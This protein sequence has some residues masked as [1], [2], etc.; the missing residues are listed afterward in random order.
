MKNE[1]TLKRVSPCA[2][3]GYPRCSNNQRPQC[4]DGTRWKIR[5]IFVIAQPKFHWLLNAVDDPNLFLCDR[6][7]HGQCKDSSRPACTDGTSLTCPDGKTLSKLTCPDGKTLNLILIAV[8]V[9]RQSDQYVQEAPQLQDQS[10]QTAL[11]WSF[12]GLK[13]KTCL[14]S[15]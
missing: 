13:G 2:A 1:L 6:P 15:D 8:L 4:S 9:Q 12:S 3:G 14:P 7:H 5:G 10:V 11:M